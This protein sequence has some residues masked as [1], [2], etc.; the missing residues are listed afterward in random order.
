M[1]SI[2]RRKKI[3]ICEIFLDELDGIFIVQR[4]SVHLKKLCLTVKNSENIDTI[5]KFFL[6]GSRLSNL[7]WMT[8][9]LTGCTL[10]PHPLVCL[11][12]LP[13]MK[14]VLC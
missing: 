1:R 8:C 2:N 7:S 10:G 12:R 3:E 5:W 13:T 4:K 6:P 11:S 9:T 14:H